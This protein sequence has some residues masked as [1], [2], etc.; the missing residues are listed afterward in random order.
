MANLTDDVLVA[1]RKIIRATDINSRRLGRQTGLT[2]PQ[3]VVLRAIAS[4]GEPTVTEISHAVSLSQA[5][6]TTILQRLET[7]GLV[8]KARSKADKRR[9]NVRLSA[10]GRK[11]QQSAPLPLQEEFTERFSR[12]QAWEQ[13]Q[14][15]SCLERVAAMM[16]AEKLD[17][18]PLLAPGEAVD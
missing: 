8:I 13:Y 18:A 1:L 11:L 12:L 4:S 10:S 14:I 9:V 5:T 3:L 16:N 15:V 17:A 6:V 2:T 7:Q